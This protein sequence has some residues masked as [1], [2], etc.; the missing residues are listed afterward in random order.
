M[1]IAVS[2]IIVIDSNGII[3]PIGMI[4][5]FKKSFCIISAIGNKNIMMLFNDIGRLVNM[6]LN[7]NLIN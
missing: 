1:L 2:L 3:I 4:S 5:F 6:L 7:P